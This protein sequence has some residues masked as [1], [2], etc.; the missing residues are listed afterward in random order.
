MKKLYKIELFV[1]KISLQSLIG[2]I[3]NQFSDE[4]L[5]SNFEGF[6]VLQSMLALRGNVEDLRERGSELKI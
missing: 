2:L 1:G 5:V 4:N 3:S 6:T